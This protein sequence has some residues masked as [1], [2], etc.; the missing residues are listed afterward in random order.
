MN[1]QGLDDYRNALLDDV[2]VVI[3]Y[4]SRAGIKLDDD[5]LDARDEVHF[6]DGSTK[7]AALETGLAQAIRAIHPITLPQLKS[8]R[9]PIVSASKNSLKKGRNWFGPRGL[10]I[11]VAI[12]LIAL[13]MNYTRSVQSY[14]AIIETA[15]SARA[16]KPQEK[17]NEL[18]VLLREDRLSP[19]NMAERKELY[20]RKLLTEAV[21]NRYNSAGVEVRN[22]RGSNDYLTTFWE[23]LKTK[24][25]S[26]APSAHTSANVPPPTAPSGSDTAGGAKKLMSIDSYLAQLQKKRGDESS[27]STWNTDHDIAG[28]TPPQVLAKLRANKPTDVSEPCRAVDAYRPALDGLDDGEGGWSRVLLNVEDLLALCVIQELNAKPIFEYSPSDVSY[29]REQVLMIS[30]WILPLLYGALGSVVYLMRN[31]TNVR[32]PYLDTSDTLFRIA[33]GSIAGIVVGWFLSPTLSDTTSEIRVSA[34]PVT[35]AF[36]AGFSIEAMFAMLDN[37]VGAL[38]NQGSGNNN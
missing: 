37:T 25:Q 12:I 36:L 22:A 4:A 34:A 29:L 6:G 17:F 21:L 15:E 5:L 32:T 16:Q 19:A 10:L 13:V 9:N 3:G 27:I 14:Q 33:M 24:F 8:D 38:R 2:N 28:L 26:D 7:L 20:E 1:A 18:L 31:R 11:I 35:F 30:G 23:W